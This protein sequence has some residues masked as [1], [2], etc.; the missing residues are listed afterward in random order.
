MV[1]Q[2]NDDV[3]CEQG[4]S[5]FGHLAAAVRTGKT[6]FH[7]RLLSSKRRIPDEIELQRL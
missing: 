5:V 4:I 6:L 2:L 1:F 3:H 7:L